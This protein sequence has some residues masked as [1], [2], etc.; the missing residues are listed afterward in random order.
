ME[1]VT[2][3]YNKSGYE[4]VSAY[5]RSAIKDKLNG[6]DNAFSDIIDIDNEIQRK[7]K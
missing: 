4:S 2:L 7:Q 5:V 3:E 6:V 1:D